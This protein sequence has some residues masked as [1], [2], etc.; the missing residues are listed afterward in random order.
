MAHRGAMSRDE[1]PAFAFD[2]VAQR[3]ALFANSVAFRLFGCPIL[4]ALCEGWDALSFWSAAV[5]FADSGGA[6]T[7][8][9]F[10]LSS[11]TQRARPRQAANMNENGARWW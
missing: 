11:R 8:R 4:R 10:A 9:R 6:G 5:R 1:E 2:F 7:R 3:F